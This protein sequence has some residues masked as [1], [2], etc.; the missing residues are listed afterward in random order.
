MDVSPWLP[1]CFSTPAAGSGTFHRRLVGFYLIVPRGTDMPELTAGRTGHVMPALC[2]VSAE[3]QKE[4][5]GLLSIHLSLS[6]LCKME[7]ARTELR[8]L[9]FFFIE[10]TE[11]DFSDIPSIFNSTAE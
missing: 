2:P 9:S 3:A 11:L 7:P 8:P 10:F 4:G 5:S 1:T 6:E